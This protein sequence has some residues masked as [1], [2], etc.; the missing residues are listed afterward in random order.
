MN[1]SYAQT[2][3][4]KSDHIYNWDKKKTFCGIKD[5]F[6]KFVMLSGRPICNKCMVNYNKS[7]EDIK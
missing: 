7:E 5:V 3:K 2:E 6:A 4:G 1:I